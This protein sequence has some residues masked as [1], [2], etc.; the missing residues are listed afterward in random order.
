[1]LKSF[2]LKVL[3]KLNQ[4][5]QICT[6]LND[7][8]QQL[9]MLISLAEL[10]LW[11]GLDRRPW[12]P[13]KAPKS[14][15]RHTYDQRD[16][17]DQRHR[18]DSD[19][20]ASLCIPALCFSFVAIVLLFLFPFLVV[21]C[22]CLCSREYTCKWTLRFDDENFEVYKARLAERSKK[23]SGPNHRVGHFI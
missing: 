9:I 10:L 1:M 3:S 20:L 13:S 17:Y 8:C 22:F 19:L 2:N 16:S 12:K 18:S 4:R 7:I 14:R 6:H 21:C 15:A 11:R 23:S 5:V